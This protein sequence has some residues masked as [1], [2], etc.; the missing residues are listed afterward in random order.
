MF[1][2]KLIWQPRSAPYRSWLQR[3]S[4]F[5]DSSQ[6]MTFWRF[7]RRSSRE[8]IMR[9]RSR[10]L[11]YFPWKLRLWLRMTGSCAFRVEYALKGM[12]RSRTHPRPSLQCHRRGV[13]QQEAPSCELTDSS[14][15]SQCCTRRGAYQRCDI[16][17]GRGSPQV[18]EPKRAERSADGTSLVNVSC[19]VRVDCFS[20]RK[21]TLWRTKIDG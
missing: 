11:P 16:S 5:A 13:L 14:R 3:V 8:P 19:A 15:P 2:S 9:S 20:F 12:H 1:M 6:K 4:P 7:W 21:I 10:R 17:G 18:S